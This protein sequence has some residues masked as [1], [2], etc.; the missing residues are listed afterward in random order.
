M[1]ASAVIISSA[2]DM[3]EKLVK[4]P[5]LKNWLEKLSDKTCL[6]KTC[7]L[8]DHSVIIGFGPGG[9]RIAK[10]LSKR[11][12]PLALIEMQDRNITEEDYSYAQVFIG[13]AKDEEVLKRAAIESAKQVII[14]V[15]EAAAAEDITIKIRKLNHHANIVVRTKYAEEVEQLYKLG[16]NHVVPEEISV[17]DTITA[18]MVG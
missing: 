15:P 5:L 4:F 1:I 7:D 12:T 14:T 3:A 6:P 16:A 11:K 10:F 9:R 18:S 2:P 17:A 8:V 13:N